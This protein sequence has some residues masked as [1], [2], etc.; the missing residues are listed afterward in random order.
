[1]EPSRVSSTELFAL[2]IL[3]IYLTTAADFSSFFGFELRITVMFKVLPSPLPDTEILP[4]FMLL[5]WLWATAG[6]QATLC[7]LMT[8]LGFSESSR[9]KEDLSPSLA[10]AG[11][12]EVFRFWI[13]ALTMFLKLTV[14]G[15]YLRL[16]MERRG[17][18]DS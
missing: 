12:F 4:G 6:L 17:F 14:I 1:M 11:V 16:L 3:K 2:L 7:K 10:S 18:E 8:L 5:P 15:F 13:L 9:L